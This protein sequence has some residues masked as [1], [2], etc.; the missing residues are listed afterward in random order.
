MH[1]HHGMSNCFEK[2]KKNGNGRPLSIP[3]QCPFQA[4]VELGVFGV[5]FVVD[6][7]ELGD[8]PLPEHSDEASLTV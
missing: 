5:A 7:C 2:L 3:L 4:H 6:G 8:V 1:L